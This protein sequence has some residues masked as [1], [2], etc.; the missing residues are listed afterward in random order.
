MFIPLYS[1]CYTPTCFNP[2][3]AILRECWYISGARSTK[4]I[5]RC[6]YQIKEQRVICYVV[7]HCL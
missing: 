4:Y 1:H 3:G 7:C 5:S 6:K 2:Q